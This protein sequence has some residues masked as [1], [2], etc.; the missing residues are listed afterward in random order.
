MCLFKSTFFS[1]VED[2]LRITRESLLVYT[3]ED[4]NHRI[5]PFKQK[6]LMELS[7]E[8]RSLKVRN[9]KLTLMKESFLKLT[10]ISVG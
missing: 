6:Q 4:I 10:S 9:V 5:L 7:A 2:S 8:E 3:D 1:H